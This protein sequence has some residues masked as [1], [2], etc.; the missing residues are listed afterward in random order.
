MRSKLKELP[1]NQCTFI[2]ATGTDIG[3]TYYLCKLLKK[4]RDY[5]SINI[6]KPIASGINLTR[7]L[8]SDTGKILQVMDKEVTLEN[9]KAITPW[10]FKEP[11]SPHLASK[12]SGNEIDFNSLKEFCMNLITDGETIIEGV[13]GIMT[14]ITYQYTNL[15]LIRS[16][17][18]SVI[19]LTG[20]YLGAISH[21]FSAIEVLLIHKVSIDK[22]IIN[23][24]LLPSI[25]YDDF[26]PLLHLT[27]VGLTVEFM[28]RD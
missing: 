27:Y 14:P 9:F 26:K 1:M 21:A 17:P 10:Y 8:E 4:I 13:G 22:V 6:V 5:R 28:P 25:S 19:L 23:E 15:D 2:T 11:L 24:S 7:L 18:C 3:K 12:A 16:L 20:N